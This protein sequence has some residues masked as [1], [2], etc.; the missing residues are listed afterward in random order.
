MWDRYTLFFYS[1]AMMIIVALSNYLVQ[2]PINDWLTYGAF[3]YPMSFL[4]TELTNRT[5]GPRVA[6]RVV[7]AGFILAVMLSIW[8]ATP[9]IALASGS[10]F[11]VA[12]LLDI[13]VFNRMRQMSWWY[14]PFFASLAASAIDT[15][16]FWTIA[17]WGEDIP[18]WSWMA[19]D[20]GVKISIDIVMLMPFRIAIRRSR[21]VPA[22]VV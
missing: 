6:R 15:G 11:L 13:F 5:Y 8:I 18:L 17:F 21:S 2:F 10:A 1:L 7:Y 3:S 19:G 20:F 16:L 9:K 22:T 14:A 4:V 12:Q